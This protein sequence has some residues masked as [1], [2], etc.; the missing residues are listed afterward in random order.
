[1][2]Q[3]ITHSAAA[4]QTNTVL[5]TAA[6]TGRTYG[7]KSIF[8]TADSALSL[9]IYSGTGVVLWRQYTAAGGTQAMTAEDDGYLFKT[10]PGDTLTYSTVGTGNTFLALNLVD[11]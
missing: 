10:L 2:S 8:F 7:V 1:M 11:I 3:Y 4:A 5:A 9:I 6:G